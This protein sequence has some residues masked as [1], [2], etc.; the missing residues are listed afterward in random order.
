MELKS[1]LLEVHK[2][3]RLQ[4]CNP[5]QILTTITYTGPNHVMD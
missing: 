1:N 2:R 5:F 4:K 3:K